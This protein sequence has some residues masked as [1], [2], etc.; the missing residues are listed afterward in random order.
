MTV[1]IAA[2]LAGSSTAEAASA[3]PPGYTLDWSVPRGDPGGNQYVELAQIHAANVHRLKPAW[4]F[5][6]GG[7]TERS[8]MHS[9][10]LIVEGL[11]YLSS[12]AMHAVAVDAATG[13]EAWR[14]D[15]APHNHGT[16]IRLRNRGLTYWAGPAGK[17]V[18]HYVKDRVYALDAKTGE[19]VTSFGGKGWI[20]LR[21]HLGVDPATV[22]LEMTNPGSVYRNLLILG[23]RVNE[24]FGSA[25]GHIRAFDTV[26]GEFKWIFHTIPQKGQFG[27]DTWAWVEGE[28]YG[29]ANAWGGVTI[30]PKRGWAFVSTGSAT[31]DYYG[32]FRKGTNLFANCVIALDATTGKRVWHYQTVH[33]DL[34]DYD[35]PPAPVLVTIRHEGKTQDAVVQLTKMGFTFV[36]NRETGEPL[37]PVHEVPVPRSG[38]PGEHAWPTQPIPAKPR[39][40]VRTALTEADLTAISPKARATVLQEFRKYISGDLYTPPSLQGTI[41]T[42]GWFGGVEWG[43]ASVDPTSNVLYV[44]ANEAPAINRVRPIY[45]PGPGD[46]AEP[47]VIGRRIYEATCMA[48]HRVGREGMPPV[49][50]SLVDVLD[51]LSADD[52][53]AVIRQ[54]R[55]SM[56]AFAPFRPAELNAL[57][58]FLRT[59]VADPAAA[60]AKPS[61]A[62]T[63]AGRPRYASEG[64]RLLVD[65]QGFPGIA[66]PWGTLN[67]VHLGTGDVLWQV[68]LGEYPALV[69]Q[70]IRNTGTLNF[71]G[72]VATAGG[73]IFIAATADEKIRAFEKHSGRVLWEHA[74]PAGG[75]AIPSIYFLNEKQY[76]VIAAGGGGKNATKAGDSIIAFALPDAAEA[77]PP[78]VVASNEAGAGWISLFDG[79]TLDGWAHLNGWHTYTAEDGAIVGRTQEGS[80]NSF[81]CTLQEFDDF[82]FEVETTVDRVTNQGIQFRSQA[83]PVTLA[84]RGGE[85]FRAGRVF[86]PQAEIRRYYPGQPTTGTL[87]G[88]ALGTGWLSSPEK[89]AKGHQHFFDEGWNQL[90][91]VARGPRMQTYVNGHLIEDIVN[92]AVYR[93]HPKGFIGLQIHGLNGREPGFVENGMQTH[94]PLLMKWR[95]IRIR[96]LP[97]TGPDR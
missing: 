11:L 91:I 43:G 51:R 56:P 15:P 83:R 4:E 23:S 87:Y 34:W 89:I 69:A 63:T 71:G 52:V 82:E 19:L 32:G 18:F 48:C 73:L 3:V 80:P 35:N 59:N 65:D 33:H 27:H 54:G 7:A 76:V 86:G 22:S 16:V 90:R 97:K 85:Q 67:A 2:M 13:R 41:M 36:L 38:I 78:P 60:E 21:E 37:F 79:K 20:D 44:N 95:N 74:L 70:G 25:P 17:R 14:F 26:T 29:G 88:E 61:T 28:T 5:R 8:N 9:N 64:T 45:L 6:T 46:S 49:I 58:A 81:L 39:S 62:A 96:P 92:E 24:A 57:V 50:P 30:D 84:G 31:E 66:P 75:Y 10:P 12:P 55:N 94:V 93:T 77:P 1:L 40:L 47:A 72:P 42:P 53:R 68:P